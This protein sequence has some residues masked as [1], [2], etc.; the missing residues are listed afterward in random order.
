MNLLIGKGYGIVFL[1]ILLGSG[2]WFLQGGCDAPAEVESILEESDEL[3]IVQEESSDVAVVQERPDRPAPPSVTPTSSPVISPE[4]EPELIDPT[5]LALPPG[6]VDLTPLY[7]AYRFDM[8]LYDL[9]GKGYLTHRWA[10]WNEFLALTGLGSVATYAAHYEEFNPE[11]PWDQLLDRY[12][13]V[14]PF[15]GVAGSPYTEESLSP[16]LRNVTTFRMGGKAAINPFMFLCDTILGGDRSHLGHDLVAPD[17]GLF[18]DG[19]AVESVR[20]EVQDGVPTILVTNRVVPHFLVF[21]DV[22]ARLLATH[23][24]LLDNGTFLTGAVSD[25]PPSA[26]SS[27]VFTLYDEAL[28]YAQLFHELREGWNTRL[29][30]QLAGRA[31][32]VNNWW[33]DRHNLSDRT[34]FWIRLRDL[35]DDPCPAEMRCGAVKPTANGEPLPIHRYVLPVLRFELL[36][37]GLVILRYQVDYLAFHQRWADG[38]PFE[39]PPEESQ[40]PETSD[41]LSETGVSGDNGK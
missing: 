18:Y 31:V 39:G 32:Q 14:A 22:N 10:S 15:R 1:V 27:R 13:K 41:D 11:T 24:R 38:V 25:T 8:N 17:D 34:A 40:A 16:E 35:G 26:P 5:S 7:R 12:S 2:G 33:H 36:R 4:P 29:T 3:E 23:V 19:S 6:P 21:T 37:Q 9:A 28:D 30:E 20:Y